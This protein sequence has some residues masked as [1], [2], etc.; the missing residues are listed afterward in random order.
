MAFSP[1]TLTCTT[2]FYDLLRNVVSELG[3]EGRKFPFAHVGQGFQINARFRL[4][5]RVLAVE[6]ER[7]P[8]EMAPDSD[9]LE[10]TSLWAQKS[11]AALASNILGL[12]AN[13]STGFA[14]VAQRPKVFT[15]NCIVADDDDLPGL[16]S[17][18]SLLTR[19]RMPTQLV[20]SQVVEKNRNLQ[21]D[22]STLL[23]DRQ[24]VV[25]VIPAS[26][27][28]DETSTRRYPA[29]TGMLEVIAA[30]ERMVERRELELM[31]VEEFKEL[32]SWFAN[33]Q[34]RFTYSTS[35]LHIWQRIANEFRLT[36]EVW[37]EHERATMT[38]KAQRAVESTILIVTALEAEAGPSLRRLSEVSPENR[39]GVY[40]NR[41][42]LATPKG[43][44]T[45]FVCSVGVGNA[46]AILN[47]TRLMEVMRPDLIVFCGIA[48]GRKEAT[49]GSVVL[50][51]LVYNYESGKER[52]EGFAPRPR[53]VTLSQSSDFLASAFLAMER[54]ADRPYEVFLK[55]VACGEKVVGTTKGASAKV[56]ASTYGDALAVEMEGFG[57]LSV[58]ERSVA[59]ALL[60]RG[61]SDLLDKKDETENHELAI[62][63]ATDLVFR[64]INYFIAAAPAKSTSSTT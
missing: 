16:E 54:S 5:G 17:L 42:T 63:N 43:V 24:G 48:G 52:P 56:I 27:S 30:V 3:F 47:T 58:L 18:I 45:V 13:P 15:C 60:V 59:P 35:S 36:P 57:F 29:A 64:L 55:P 8:V 41:G 9:L 46:K 38:A 34:R 10:Q 61:I 6:I 22:S 20:V 51:S 1:T 39:D 49:I 50:A 31:S 37:I 62:E 28:E 4:Y 25:A 2:R 12:I 40:V 11:I 44:A 14:A 32:A 23:V 19:H 33:P 26:L 21:S 53:L 7:S